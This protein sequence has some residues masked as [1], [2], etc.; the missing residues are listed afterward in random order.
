[1]G[2]GV[3]VCLFICVRALQVAQCTWIERKIATTLFGEPPNA[4]VHEAL[5][6]FLKV[7]QTCWVESL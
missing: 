4:T 7:G 3:F 6:N 1:M 2:L 5:Q